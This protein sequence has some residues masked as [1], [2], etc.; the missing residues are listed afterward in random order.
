MPWA[1]SVVG[2]DVVESGL[3]EYAIAKGGHLHL[4]LEFFGGD[5]QPTNTRLVEEAVALCDRLGVAVATCDEAAAIL[6][7]PRA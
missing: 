5:R 6:D 4:G 3:A 1:V 2:G 7:L